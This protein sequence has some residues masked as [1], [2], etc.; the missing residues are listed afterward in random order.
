MAIVI[1]AH[2]AHHHHHTTFLIC[3][4]GI[5]VHFAY[6][7]FNCLLIA[8]CLLLV[9]PPLGVRGLNPIKKAAAVGS[10]FFAKLYF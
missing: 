3:Y 8:Y 7:C 4:C 1:C 2:H 9:V 10:G 6:F 5:K